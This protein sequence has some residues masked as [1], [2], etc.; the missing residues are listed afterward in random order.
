MKAIVLIADY[1]TDSLAVGEVSLAL[2]RHLIA[3][4]PIHVVASRPFSTI[5]TGFL[6]DQL[7]RHLPS[8]EASQYVFFL[9]TDPRTHTEAETANAEGSPLYVARLAN[10][11]WVVTPNAGHCLSF[12]KP[13]IAELWKAR[14]PADGTQFRSRDLFPSVVAAVANGAAAELLDSAQT[15]VVPDLPAGYVVLHTDN[16]GNVK[17]SFTK[18]EASRLG[19]GWGDSAVV[20]MA[21]REFLVP[22]RQTI[23]AD[24]PGELV[25]APGS[26]GS[27][28]DPCLELSVRYAGNVEAA[29]AAQL[30]GSPEPGTPIRIE[31]AKR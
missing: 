4:L 15:S 8:G 12:V 1:G 29:S 3:P 25:F 26:S 5:H 7:Q 9:N 28:A 20:S 16:Y 24:K 27:P 13:S 14:C 2:S 10:G 18:A 11:A 22:L 19:L 17:T 31:P 21:K 23:F 6:L 30:F